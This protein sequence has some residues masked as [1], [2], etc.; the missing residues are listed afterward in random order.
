M[1]QMFK[2]EIA[3]EAEEQAHATRAFAS[4]TVHKPP[5]VR[6]AWQ[7]EYEAPVTQEAI[8]NSEDKEGSA[9][10]P[11]PPAAADGAEV[12]MAAA[13]VVAAAEGAAVW[14]TTLPTM[15]RNRSENLML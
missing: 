4:P 1:E 8:A 11:S 15:A 14:A 7:L 12:G 2:H 6:A 5:V 10:I 3:W 9:V 13:A